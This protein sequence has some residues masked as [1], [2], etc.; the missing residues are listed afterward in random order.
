MAATGSR[1]SS[2]GKKKS[3]RAKSNT[4]RKGTRGKS[5]TPEVSF[6]REVILWIVVAISLLLFISNFGFGGK[7]GNAF[8]RFFFGIFGLIAYIFPIVLLVGTFFAVSNKGNRL[9]TVKIIATVLFVSFL[10]M[11]I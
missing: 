2:S 11:F 8:S 1:K 6:E 4:S 9:A 5:K 7:I 3:T 10:C